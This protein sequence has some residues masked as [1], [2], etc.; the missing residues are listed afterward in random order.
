MKKLWLLSFAVMMLGL[1]VL[2]AEGEELAAQHVGAQGAT[3]TQQQPGQKYPTDPNA[4]TQAEVASLIQKAN[5]CILDREA[6]K[7]S[8]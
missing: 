5:A 2:A 1:N 8:R 3:V 7:A 4:A 6:K